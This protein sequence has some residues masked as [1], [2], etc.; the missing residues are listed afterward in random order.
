[1]LRSTHMQELKKYPNSLYYWMKVEF[2][3]HSNK[4]EGSTFTEEQLALLM[5]KGIVLGEHKLEDIKETANSLEL[6]EYM[7]ENLNE[8]VTEDLILS[9]HKVL[10]KGTK[11][12]EAGLAGIWKKYENKILGIA[13]K[14]AHPSE[15][16][17]RIKDLLYRWEHSNQAFEDIA[18][19][20]VDFEKIHPFQDGNGRVGRFLMLKQCFDSGISPIVI[21]WA[22]SKQY[23]E[24]LGKAQVTGDMTDFLSVLIQCQQRFETKDILQSTLKAFET[25]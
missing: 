4:L 12:E 9:F 2:L 3:F 17:E 14:L 15:V 21:D 22:F 18:L 7:V 11:E 16:R 24:S 23:K 8:P 25:N 6:F 13:V 20:H 5:D 19:F 1:M 10:K